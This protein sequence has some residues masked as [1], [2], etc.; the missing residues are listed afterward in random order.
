[1]KSKEEIEKLL[2]G[3][4]KAWPEDGSIVEGVMRKIESA[5]VR[6][7]LPK[8]RRIIMKSLIGIAASVAVFAALLWGVLGD[9]NSL[10]AQV[11]EAV[12]KART[13]H[14]IQYAQPKD[15][16]KPIKTTEQW[17]ERGVGFRTEGLGQ[18]HLGNDEYLWTF[19]KDRNI[20]VRSK[21]DGIDKAMAPIFSNTDQ[22]AQEVAKANV[23][24]TRMEIKRLTARHAKHTW[25]KNWS[26]A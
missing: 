12:H 10:Y 17:F 2:E 7:N 24:D 13:F 8:R 9:R 15:G 5:P 4:G 6:R 14:T 25:K 11:I 18:I 1:M 22:F 23:S 21:S 19:T 20:A 16:A 3:F 26:N